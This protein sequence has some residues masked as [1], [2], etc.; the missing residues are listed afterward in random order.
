MMFEL[1]NLSRDGHLKRS[2]FVSSFLGLVSAKISDLYQYSLKISISVWQEKKRY[3][4][5][6]VFS[7]AVIMKIIVWLEMNTPKTC[8]ITATLT[9]LPAK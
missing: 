3:C 5:T 7:Q 8:K 1:D 9:L 4:A 2:C 6:S